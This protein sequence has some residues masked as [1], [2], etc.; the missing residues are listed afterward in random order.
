[1]SQAAAETPASP[2]KEQTVCLVGMPNSGKTTLMN[3]LTG[4]N[5][6][7]A[8]YPGVTVSLLRGSSRPEFGATRSIIDLPG[9]HSSVAPSPEEEL[10][11]EVI[12]GRHKRVKP[13]AF[14]LVVDATQLER[15]LKF[16]GLVGRQGKPTVIALTM[17]DLLGRTGQS[18]NP[19]KLSEALGV[20]VIPVDPRT[21]SGVKELF[22]ALDSLSGLLWMG[23]A[24]S[25]IPAEPVE[26]F[27]HVAE[28][29]RRS[30]AV[31]HSE[32][33]DTLS[34]RIDRFVL[35]RYF[36]FP[37]FFLVLVS[38]FASIFWAAK[39]FQNFVDGTFSI[40]APR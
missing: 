3:A 1:M 19:S 9:V 21:G 12:E 7:T 20:P 11:V 32:H 34:S 33:G 15:H 18:V 10:A 29:L 40:A 17:V 23:N 5:F 30:G 31:T 35:H 22:V 36:G 6:K 26:G 13:D 25:G 14:I 28:I 8:N 16:A 24:L 38:L 2:A 27:K 39:P 37:I 4:G